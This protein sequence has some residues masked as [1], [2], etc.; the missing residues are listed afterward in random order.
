MGL[1][2]LSSSLMLN[3]C[4]EKTYVA[5]NVLILKKSINSGNIKYFPQPVKS[6]SKTLLSNNSFNR[7]YNVGNSIFYKK[8]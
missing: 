4:V 6:N 8:F 5:G 2:G 7:F 1:G 3:K